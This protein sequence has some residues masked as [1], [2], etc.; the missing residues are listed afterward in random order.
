MSSNMNSPAD[1]KRVYLDVCTLCRP[2]DDQ[3]LVRI[4]LETSAVELILSHVRQ[5]EIALI[6]SPAHDVE[7][8][9]IADLEERSQLALLL[10]QLGTR[11]RFD[12]SAARQ[13]AEYL[14]AQ[15]LGVADAAHVAFAEHAQADFVTVDDQLIK[16]CR[17]IRLAIWCGTPPL[18]CE[19]EN[20]R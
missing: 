5:K 20:L 10:E 2:F 12:L 18:Y 14:A 11:P 1:P 3:S 7:I 8:G 13:R 9:A 4:R 16:K 15:R 17:R 6:V 19:K